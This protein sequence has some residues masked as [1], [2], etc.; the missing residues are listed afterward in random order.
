MVLIMETVVSDLFLQVQ[1][2][3]L[4][5]NLVAQKDFV[6]KTMVGL[7]STLTIQL[8]ML[9]LH[10]VILLVIRPRLVIHQTQI[11]YYTL[12]IRMAMMVLV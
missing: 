4:K 10:T 2:Q 6:Y 8:D 7:E 5:S 12:R 3:D 9:A 1:T 11:R